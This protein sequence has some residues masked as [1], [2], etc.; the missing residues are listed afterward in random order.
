[1]KDF[2]GQKSMEKLILDKKNVH[3]SFLPK[4]F[5]KNERLAA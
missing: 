3:F 2:Q 1:M 4:H 5:P